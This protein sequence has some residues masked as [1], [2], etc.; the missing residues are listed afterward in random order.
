MI[1]IMESS[2]FSGYDQNGVG[3][4]GERSRLEDKL[5][6]MR[7]MGDALYG[8]ARPAEHIAIAPHQMALHTVKH[9]AKRLSSTAKKA[10][11]PRSAA[12]AVL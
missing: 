1:G 4:P 8:G 3:F 2:N 10:T 5:V 12:I 11:P 7:W 9:S 6:C